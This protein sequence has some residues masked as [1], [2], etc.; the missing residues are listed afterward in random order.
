MKMMVWLDE[1][2]ESKCECF[3]SGYNETNKVCNVSKHSEIVAVKDSCLN[4]VLN[5]KMTKHSLVAVIL[6][7]QMF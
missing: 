6:S 7:F 1:F 3:C 4:H 2:I 5:F